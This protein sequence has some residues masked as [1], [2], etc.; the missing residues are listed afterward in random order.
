MITGI[1]HIVIVVR[2]L[3]AAIASYRGL[4]FTV[5]PGGRHPVGTHNAL[6]AL[7]D[8]AYIEL[9]AF[10]EPEKPETHRWWKPLQQGEGLADFCVGTSDL[11]AEVGALRQSGV[12]IDD[13][14]PLTRTRPDGYLLR[15]VLAIPREGHRGV[16]PFLISDETP[17]SERVPA[18]T[19]HQNQV[20]GLGPLTVAVPELSEVRR[21][22]TR[23]L[24]QS[25][26]EGR[27]DD[28][29]ALVVQFR[30][31]AHTLEFVAPEHD[32]SPLTAFL[33]N[34]GP[35]PYAAS[36]TSNSK[37]TGWLDDKAAHG[38]RLCLGRGAPPP[39]E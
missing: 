29:E 15:W 27:R 34:R 1:D 5:V 20:I 32:R 33:Q 9:I 24:G 17:R 35:G 11:R 3:D 28:L 36:L 21:W 13:P 14:A 2:D 25:G 10:L 8:G 12:E 26:A 19:G 39:C 6:I 18:Q 23:L 37:T 22:Y 7:E 16:A 30:A 31:G 38:A 4:G